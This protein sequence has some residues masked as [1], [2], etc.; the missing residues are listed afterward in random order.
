[1][2][3]LSLLFGTPTVMCIVLTMAA[4]RGV[5]D[6]ATALRAIRIST[7]FFVI[8][9]VI[10]LSTHHTV[11]ATTIVLFF[12]GHVTLTGGWL[13]I[14]GIM[15]VAAAAI[16]P[17]TTMAGRFLEQ[18]VA[19]DVPTD[20]AAHG[21]EDAPVGPPTME[22]PAQPG[23]ESPLDGLPESTGDLIR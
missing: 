3:H 14:A 10:T 22:Q 23:G 18:H 19:A 15:T 11:G 17:S 16:H 4:A 7:V 13:V 2:G 20:A 8:S 12:V 6:V 1:M 21:V 5:K 9:C